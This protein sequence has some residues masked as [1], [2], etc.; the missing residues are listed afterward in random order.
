MEFTRRTAWILI[1]LLVLAVHASYIGG[2]FIGIDHGDIEGSRAILPASALG[3]VF[4]RP[5]GA[6]GFFRPLVT[7]ANSLDALVYG[8]WA[9][10]FHVTS[11]FLHLAFVVAAGFFAR[12]FFRLEPWESNIVMLVVGVHPLSWPI[13]GAVHYRSEQLAALFVLLAVAF[14]IKARE[15]RKPYFI[16]FAVI[17]LLAA[18]LSKEAAV[19]WIAGLIGFFE[20]ERVFAGRA[21]KQE[22]PYTLFI[23]E[24]GVI[25]LYAL[26]RAHVIK[27]V[28]RVAGVSLPLFQALGTRLETIGYQLFY[29][30]NPFLPPLSDATPVVSLVHPIPIFVILFAAGCLLV[31][32]RAGIGSPVSR[33]LIFLGIALAPALNIVP[34]PRFTS[35]HYGYLATLGAGAA[36]ALALR[37]KKTYFYWIGGLWVAIMAASTFMGGFRFENDQT[38]FAPEVARDQNFLEG[39][40]YIGNY[41]YAL[42]DYE[43]A[44]R[45]FESALLRSSSRKFIA[46]F[47]TSGTLVNLAGVR[48]EE[49]RFDEAD[50]LLREAQNQ[51]ATPNPSIIYNRAVVAARK[52]EARLLAEERQ[53]KK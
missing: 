4:S 25:I 46:Y 23:F 16:F 43:N 13:V 33:T 2:G 15:G 47:D 51:S 48:L 34:L 42:G 17:S 9:P 39:Y 41:Y 20:V 49:G 40:Y 7:L 14:H 22:I 52:E 11:I 1:L 21:L 29:L 8:K 12:I 28:W 32:T 3:Q 18:L 5:F 37:H 19:F 31:I 35:P 10:G 26:L 6:T 44:S 27:E 45:Y 38:L 24:G 36:A 53:D 50:S 30:V